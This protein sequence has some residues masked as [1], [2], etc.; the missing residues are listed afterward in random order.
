M[1]IAMLTDKQL[2]RI[3]ESDNP[4]EAGY[5]NIINSKDADVSP[6]IWSQLRVMAMEILEFRRAYGPLGCEWL[7]C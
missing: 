1:R 5:R 7:E 4:K 2:E 3:A 6:F